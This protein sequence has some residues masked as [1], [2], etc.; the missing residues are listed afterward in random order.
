MTIQTVPQAQC[1][2]LLE[3]QWRARIAMK[4]NPKARA[5]NKAL[6]RMYWNRVQYEFMRRLQA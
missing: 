5:K 1:D 4:R 2:R 3:K 6:K